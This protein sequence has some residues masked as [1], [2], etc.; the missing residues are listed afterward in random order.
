MHWPMI[1]RQ[2]VNNKVNDS[3]NSNNDKIHIDNDDNDYDNENGTNTGNTS[4]VCVHMCVCMNG[5]VV[6]MY[7]H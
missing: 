6:C 7:I 2:T 5:C 4:K 3:H 1:N